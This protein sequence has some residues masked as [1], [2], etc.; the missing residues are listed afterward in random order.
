M[1][2]TSCGT[3]YLQ[4]DNLESLFPCYT[5]NHCGGNLF[6]LS[7]FL[8]WKENNKEAELKNSNAAIEAEETSKAMIC[9]KSG[10][11]MTKYR[12]ASDTDHRLDLSPSIGA[13]W[14]DKGEWELL[15]EKGLA[16]SVNNIFTD[17]WQHDV[18][19][20]ESADIL[21]TLYK[22]KFGDNYEAIK[23]FR[24]LINDSEYKSEVL[25]YLMAED[26]YQP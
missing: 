4:A 5:C 20:Q 19:S 3:G 17:H 11:L 26:P 14:L 22:K 1:K 23:T 2:C 7:D 12:I 8:R 25:A 16:S 24:A 21:T 18:R 9:P 13:V 6:M 10:G 15:K